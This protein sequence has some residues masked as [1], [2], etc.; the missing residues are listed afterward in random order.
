MCCTSS[1]GV[2]LGHHVSD[3]RLSKT[4]DAKNDNKATGLSSHCLSIINLSLSR[5]LPVFQIM[6]TERNALL[7][8]ETDSKRSKKKKEQ[9][10]LTGDLLEP[11]LAFFVFSDQ[12]Q[13]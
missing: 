2:L 12:H 5:A 9:N 1:T 10:K 13:D 8:N 4:F 11:R 7:R 6:L 3:W